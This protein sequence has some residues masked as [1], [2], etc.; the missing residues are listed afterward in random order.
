MKVTFLSHCIL[1]TRLWYNLVLICNFAG[2]CM[3]ASMKTNSL[4]CSFLGVL[5]ILPMPR[6]TPLPATL[7]GSNL[8]PLS[9]WAGTRQCTW[10]A[11]WWSAGSGTTPPTATRAAAPGPGE[12]SVLL[13][14]KWMWWWDP[15]SSEKGVLRVGTLGKPN[16]FLS[17][18]LWDDQQASRKATA[19]L[20][21]PE[22]CFCQLCRKKEGISTLQVSVFICVFKK[23]HCSGCPK[24]N[25][26]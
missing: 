11:R 25:C 21:V 7:L 10:S 4:F 20:P 3:C 18:L 8:T 5:E 19:L 23:C 26:L 17:Y 13:R 2:T 24:G 12:T 1:R 16:K 6:S 22:I 15:F 9:S 14:K